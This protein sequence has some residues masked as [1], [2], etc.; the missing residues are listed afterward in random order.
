MGTQHLEHHDVKLF[1][2]ATFPVDHMIKTGRNDPCPCGSGKK[3]KQCCGSLREQAVPEK[4]RHSDIPS[5]ESSHR[6][7][8]NPSQPTA[9]EMNRLIALFRTGRHV[10]LETQTR[11]LLERYP[12][13]GFAWNILGVSLQAQGKEALAALQKAAELMPNDAGVHSNLGNSLRELGRFTDAAASYR[14]ALEIR[15]G[16][17]EAHNNLGVALRDLKRLDEAVASFHKAL[18]IK[19]D[20]AEAYVN[21]GTTLQDLNQ[22]DGAMAIYRRVLEIKP[23]YIEAYNSLGNILRDL[24]R[25]DDA[26]TN[27]RRALEIKPSYAEAH[28]NLGAALQALGQFDAAEESFRRALEIKPDFAGAYSN[29]GNALR[30]QGKLD[31]AVASYRRALEIKPDYAEAHCNLGAALHALG[32]LENAAAS[33]YRSLEIKPLFADAHNNLG[34][35]LR[36]L[37]QL[38]NAIAGYRRA[39]EIKPDFAEAHSNLGNALQALGQHE[40]AVKSFRRALEIKPDFA[41][42]HSN[43]GTT[44]Q[45]IGQLDKA[46]ESIQKALEIRPD[47]AEAHINLGIALRDK[48]DL[49]GAKARFR[50][51]HELGFDGARVREA[52]ALP[53]IMGTKQDVLESRAE[54][55]RQLDELIADKVK[56]DD[57]LKGVGET[58]F[59][60]AYHG[61]NDRDLQVKVAKF[62]EQACPSLLYTAPHCGQPKPDTQKT[63]RVGFLSRFLYSHSVSKCYSKIIETLSLKEQLEVTLI[64]DN[65]INEEIYSEFASTRVR[66]PHNLAQSREILAAL[67][68]DVLVY[69]DIGME[70]LSYFLAFARLARVQCVLSGHPVTTGITN[71]DYFLSTELMEPSD[72][73]RHYSEKLVLLP[74]PLFYFSRP[75][76]PA[77]LKT[78]HELGL[79]ENRNIYI[80]P[81]RL[82][83]IHPDFDDAIGRILQMDTNGVV[84]LFEDI[85]LSDGK[86]ILLERFRRRI[87]EALRERILFLPWLTESTDFISAIATANIILDPFHFGI[88]STAAMA[89]TTGTPLVTKAGEF[90]RG[91]VGLGL[92]KMMDL[93][94]CL[95]EDTES[96]ARKAV[97]IASN[98]SLRNSISVKMLKNSDVLYENLQPVDDF[99]DFFHSLK[100]RLANQL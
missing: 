30:D 34:A 63:I 62:Y 55:E 40:E 64:S 86:K 25:F 87:Q 78:R 73:N 10:E 65:P 70:P 31:D 23:D 57:P 85:I 24:G 48:G 19:P 13:S 66:L 96:Y 67:E 68:L 47:Y 79:P 44:L 52:L 9:V 95:A 1:D 60:L 14:R 3:F 15:P 20:Y 37:G 41:E 12:H 92:C 94:E 84:V 56:L 71:M 6:P 26:V 22:L 93:P 42:A 91:R 88:G 75:K 51:A 28:C 81:M 97:Q 11:L 49:R 29:L 36:D 76:L 45:A 16:F 82:Q 4:N 46:V 99:I 7:P 80:C 21:L 100:E 5:R 59:Y 58:N 27:F 74:R 77:T 17:A 69:L 72:A 61:V 18:E 43:L 83:K 39:L 90:M 8:T 54:F 53:A 89:F 50:K 35:I 33:C 2:F 32:Q 98:P 38:D